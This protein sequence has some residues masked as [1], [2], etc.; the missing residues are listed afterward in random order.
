M[1]CARTSRLS[2][3]RH[4]LKPFCSSVS[5]LLASAHAFIQRF[6]TW[7]NTL[8]RT[9]IIVIGL[10]SLGKLAFPRFCT[11]HTR[12]R[13]QSAG[14]GSPCI[15]PVKIVARCSRARSPR[16]FTSPSIMP[17]RPL[18]VHNLILEIAW[19]MA[20]RVIFHWF[21]LDWWS[22]MVWEKGASHKVFR[23]GCCHI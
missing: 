15:M 11:R 3:R 16:H 19:S 13:S 6:Q 12:P 22:R 2:R 7:L 14:T 20:R 21:S 9:L 1:H 17:S 10:W 18:A 4:S 23:V 5:S 8:Y